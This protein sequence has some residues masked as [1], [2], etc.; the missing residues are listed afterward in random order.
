MRN[1]TDRT[2]SGIKFLERNGFVYS[3]GW[4]YIR[5]H[6]ELYVGSLNSQNLSRVLRN[7]PSVQVHIVWFDDLRTDPLLTVNK[8]FEFL[9]VEPLS[10]L[11]KLGDAKVNSG[12]SP[13]SPVLSRV[14]KELAL[15]ARTVGA[16]RIVQTLKDSD[17]VR[18]ILYTGQSRAMPEDFDDFVAGL[19]H[20]FDDDIS[21]LSSITGR[22]LSS[23]SSD[24]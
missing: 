22:D 4:E 16:D 2:V 12:A 10:K 19:R 14:V 6:P 13:R 18:Q 7:F 9:E 20:E 11:P 24:V 23:W 3:S 15:R 5:R 8:L 17:R 21:L 1:P